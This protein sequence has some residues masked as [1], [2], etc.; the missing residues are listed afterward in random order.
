MYYF[1][2]EKDYFQLADFVNKKSFL[3]DVSEKY[4]LNKSQHH[5]HDKLKD[6]EVY[7]L[8]EHQS[9][10]DK[11][12][13]VRIAEY[14]LAIL[15]SRMFE[16]NN[17]NEKNATIVPLVIYS[18]SPQWTA[19]MSLEEMQEKNEE[20]LIE[21]EGDEGMLH[22]QMVIRRDF[23]NARRKARQEGRQEGVLN[24]AKKML[25]EKLD[26]DF[27]SKITGLKKEEFMK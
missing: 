1:Y 25:S 26:V 17:N 20:I 21:R 18:G 9:K 15:K 6:R 23:E 8:I 13:P 12:M 11:N 22:A 16:K 14:S 5:K 2:T 4:N 7:F 24:I 3:S 27:I 10:V 19:K